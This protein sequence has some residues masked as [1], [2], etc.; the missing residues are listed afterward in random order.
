[1]YTILEFIKGGLFSSDFSVGW[2]RVLD[3]GQG[4]DGPETSSKWF[5]GNF[6]RCALGFE[7]KTSI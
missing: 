2:M 5:L 3:F 1:V 7:P 6:S 4:S